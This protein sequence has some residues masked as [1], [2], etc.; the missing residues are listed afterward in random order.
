[1]PPSAT[2]TQFTIEDIDEYPPSPLE[3]LPTELPLTQLENEEHNDNAS[4]DSDDNCIQEEAV[5]NCFFHVMDAFAKRKSYVGKMKNKSFAAPKGTAYRHVANIASTKTIEQRRVV[6]QLYLQDW[7]E[8]RD[9]KAAADHLEKE[10]CTYP[11]YNWNY[12]CT[13]EVGVYP[14]NC[15]NESFNRHGIKSVATDCTKNASLAAFLVH[16]APR[17]LEE[18][19]NSRSDPCTIEIPRTAS[20]FAVGVTG[21]VQEGH[22]IV[23]LGKN[24]YG[25][26]SSWLA[27]ISYKIGVPIDQARIRRVRAS[28]E[29]DKEFFEQLCKSQ[30]FVPTADMLADMMMRATTTVCHLEWKQGNIVGDCQD[31][32][33]HL[34]YS[35][36]GAIFLRSKHNL[37][38]CSLEILRKTDANARG[39]AAKAFSRG[40]SKR[41]YQSGLSR[42]TKRRCRSKM[43][44]SFDGYLATLNHQ[45]LTR[46]VLYLGLFKLDNKC[47]DPL[48][49][50]TSQGLLDMLQSFYDNPMGYRAMLLSRPKDST[51]YTVVKELAGNLK[52]A[53]T[54]FPGKE[55]SKKKNV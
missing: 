41:L 7:R 51:R 32:V 27:N 50:K 24:E 54:A 4:T 22:D 49:G 31:C 1:M 21:F 55:N 47:P 35:C 48:H 16:T 53:T 8:N 11:R 45:Q 36:P 29:G 20:V 37:L 42:N 46:L 14:T 23:E 44:H 6:T 18:D 26:P 28:M 9:E 13:G 39:D 34:G 12:A 43:L 17:L 40:N 38:T 25:K 5:L 2:R 15:P 52:Q 19:A 10:Y 3:D 30:G 33:K